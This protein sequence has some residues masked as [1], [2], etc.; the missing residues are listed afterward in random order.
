MRKR[1]VES[2]WRLLCS[3]QTGLINVKLNASSGWYVP[4]FFVVKVEQKFVCSERGFEGR[5]NLVLSHELVHFLQ[6]FTSVYCMRGVTAMTDRFAFVRHQYGLNEAMPNAEI[7]RPVQLDESITL[8]HELL[9]SYRGETE[10]IVETV[11]LQNLRVLEII[12]G[13]L[14]VKQLVCEFDG[15]ADIHQIGCHYLLESM[16]DAAERVLG[17]E[18][19]TP[20]FPYHVDEAILK[21]LGF[22]DIPAHVRLLLLEHALQTL[23]N[24]APY[25]FWMIRHAA[26]KQVDLK[27]WR[28]VLR[29]LEDV[30]VEGVEG[31][32]V[33]PEDRYSSAETWIHNLE[34]LVQG[35][36]K[37]CNLNLINEV[38]SI[39]DHESGRYP[40]TRL[41]CRSKGDAWYFCQ[42]VLNKYVGPLIIDSHNE[43]IDVA[44]DESTIR[45][46][47]I[48]PALL[49][50]DEVLQSNSD[51]KCKLIDVCSKHHCDLVDEHCTSAPWK[52]SRGSQI[53]MFDSVLISNGMHN[54]VFNSAQRG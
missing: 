21:S 50:L 22:V 10:Q 48:F 18:R 27:Q 9:T 19:S 24:P 14:Q 35:G 44:D 54:A 52:R 16:A 17:S 25:Y 30:Y 41:V 39:L 51:V 28:S 47:M 15:A 29:F 49:T 1:T 32:R 20:A 43:L 37:G 5:G 13:G 3:F 4:S 8:N 23:E 31:N 26:K 2:D 46:P 34:V 53:C 42:H 36:R 7:L 11:T 12:I 6:D 33:V 45:Q 38:R 40:I